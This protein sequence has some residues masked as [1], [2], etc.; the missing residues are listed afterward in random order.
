M[1]VFV[2]QID[3]YLMQHVRGDT[4]VAQRVIA[5]AGTALLTSMAAAAGVRVDNAV[6]VRNCVFSRAFVADAA[7]VAVFAHV[8]LVGSAADAPSAA[9]RRVAPQ[10]R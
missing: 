6:D 9:Q 2:D 10:R 8:L 5:A 1:Q 4:N 3:D 7:C